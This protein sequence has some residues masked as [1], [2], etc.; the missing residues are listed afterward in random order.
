MGFNSGLKGLSA[1]TRNLFAWATFR[2]RF[3]TLALKYWLFV[4]SVVPAEG[5]PQSP[6]KW[7]TISM[8]LPNTHYAW[9][10]CSS[11]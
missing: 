1:T 5:L 2:L 9:S 7:I 10:S 8:Q 11:L 4:S 6:W 3:Y